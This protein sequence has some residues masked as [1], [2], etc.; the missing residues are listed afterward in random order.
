MSTQESISL[1]ARKLAEKWR[2]YATD[3]NPHSVRN[4]IQAMIAERIV[5]RTEQGING[6]KNKSNLLSGKNW[7]KYH[8]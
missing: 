3:D 2:Q 8:Q 6:E 5:G 4:E 7:H 1:R